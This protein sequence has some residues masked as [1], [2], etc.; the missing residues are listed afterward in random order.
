MK[1][2]LI[3]HGETDLNKQKRFQ[4]RKDYPLNEKGIKQVEA[5]SNFLKD[6]KIDKIITSPLQR[7]SKTAE[8]INKYHNLNIL[9]ENLALERDFGKLDGKRYEEVVFKKN[10]LLFYKENNIEN[11]EEFTSRVK[12][13][14]DKLIKNETENK[15]N[16]NKKKDISKENEKTII[17]T[18]HGGVIKVL[19]AIIL[20][21]DYYKA[22]TQ[23][24][25]SNC[26][27]TEIELPKNINYNQEKSNDNNN[28]IIIHRINYLPKIF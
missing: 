3:R 26:S 1:L 15:S 25:I 18:T 23:I 11:K 28:S 6:I 27:I 4:G 16:K 21:I 22:M 20:D 24:K 7:A 14:L 5:I 17:L 12:K 13:L 2:L 8:I 19:L 10:D 9:I